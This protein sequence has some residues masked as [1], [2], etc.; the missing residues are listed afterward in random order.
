MGGR[1]A[2]PAI[3]VERTTRS[4]STLL[5][6]GKVKAPQEQQ[7][8]IREGLGWGVAGSPCQEL[9]GQV[10]LAALCADHT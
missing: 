5:P 4:E 6:D 9:A 2:V 10:A 8:Q 1:G 3:P 7:K